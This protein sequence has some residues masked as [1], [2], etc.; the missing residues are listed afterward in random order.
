MMRLSERDLDIV[1][2]TVYGESRGESIQGKAAVAWVIRNRAENPG[3][4]GETVAEVCLKRRQFSCWD[5]DNRLQMMLADVE[6]AAYAECMAATLEVFGAPVRDDLTRGA[7][8]YHTVEI[9]PRWAKDRKPV[10]QIGGHLFYR[11]EIPERA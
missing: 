8:H 6:N 7:D 9:S 10:V 11:L 5:D 3:W 1:A 4:W 2:R